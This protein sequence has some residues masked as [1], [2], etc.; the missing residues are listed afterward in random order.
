MWYNEERFGVVQSTAIADRSN[1]CF[2]RK[3]V[4]EVVL[5]CRS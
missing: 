1:E 2:P 4:T 3:S 5:G